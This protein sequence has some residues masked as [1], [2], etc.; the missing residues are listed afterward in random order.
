MNPGK[1]LQLAGVL[2][3]TQSMYQQRDDLSSP[4]SASVVEQLSAWPAKWL[5]KMYVW[6][7]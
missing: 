4:L 3:L 1:N 2:K 5:I 6:P 7:P